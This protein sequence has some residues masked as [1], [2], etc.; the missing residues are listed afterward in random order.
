MTDVSLVSALGY[1][2]ARGEVTFEKHYPPIS[3]PLEKEKQ[4]ILP[5]LGAFC[6][7]L[8]KIHQI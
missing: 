7:N 5:K 4:A 2:A 6:N 1:I 8:P 3:I